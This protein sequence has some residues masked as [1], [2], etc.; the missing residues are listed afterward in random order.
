[1]NRREDRQGV[2]HGLHGGTGVRAA[3]RVCAAGLLA[4][5]PAVS[6]QGT[7]LVFEAEDAHEVEAPMVR[8]RADAP[9]AGVVAVE[10]A[11]GNAYLAI[12]QGA[13]NPPK[14]T[15]GQAV[16]HVRIPAAGLYTLWLRTYWDDSCGNSINVRINETAP[17]T[18][19]DSTYQTWHW[20]RSPPRLRQLLLPEGPM[21]LTLINREDGVRIDQVLLT[22]SRQ[23][24]PVDIEPVT[25]GAL[26]EPP[27][28]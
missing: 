3:W 18:V 8:V 16:Y 13:G 2:R 26:E 23:M 12:P 6:A 10:G 27:T 1:M 14:V 17:F 9:P 4:L 20:V 24:I 25:P 28:P 7:T 19:Q 5:L 15:T 22:T 21:T 11:S